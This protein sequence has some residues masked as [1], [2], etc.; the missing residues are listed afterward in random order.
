MLIWEVCK[1]L[2]DWEVAHFVDCM[3]E[4][5]V[6]DQ[7]TSNFETILAKIFVLSFRGGPK[8]Q[9]ALLHA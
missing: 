8:L 2:F 6:H 7:G 5:V 3:V 9:K 1:F 4:T